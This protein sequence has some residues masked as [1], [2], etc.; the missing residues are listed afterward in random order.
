MLPRAV[1]ELW[2]V[3]EVRAVLRLLPVLGSLAALSS[4]LAVL[5]LSL[6]V[7]RSLAEESAMV[8]KSSLTVLM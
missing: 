5:R 1:L 3:I 8:G 4:S 2:F 7:L 6:A